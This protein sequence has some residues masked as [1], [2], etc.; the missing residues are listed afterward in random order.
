MQ[1]KQ[2]EMKGLL[3]N[4]TYLIICEK[5]GKAA[6]IDPGIAGMGALWKFRW[7]LKVIKDQGLT[8]IYI[9]NTHRHFDHVKGNK[10]FAGKTGAEIL[11]YKS[12]LRENDEIEI[13]EAKLKVIESPGHTVDGIS[14]YSDKNLFTGDTLFVGDSG[15]T[16][17]PDSDRPQLGAS[18]RKLIEQC[19][20]DTVVWPGHDLGKTKTTTLAR[21]Q[22]ENC[23]SEE[24][25]LKSV[26]Y[27]GS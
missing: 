26:S 19:P 15:A 17:S 3:K 23:N 10:Y 13:G 6:L 20:P 11:S 4:F 8:L 5:T 25:R 24:Y 7:V 2:L 1:I 9:I 12:G 22:E 18:L 14:L 21:E 16:V 27:T